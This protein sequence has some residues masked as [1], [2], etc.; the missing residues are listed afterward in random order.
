MHIN[1]RSG[2]LCGTLEQLAR[3]ARCKTA[4]FAHALADLQTTGTAA[5]TIRNGNVTVSNRR[6][7]REHKERQQ[8]KIRMQRFRGNGTVTPSVT[9][10]FALDVYT[11]TD[12]DTDLK[13][14]NDAKPPDT[15]TNGHLNRSSFN[16]SQEDEVMGRLRAFVGEDEMARAGGHWRQD[17]VRKHPGLVMRAIEDLESREKEGATYRNRGAALEDTIKRW[18]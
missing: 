5:V 17:H 10:K 15:P 1:G 14:L 13:R 9:Q 18:K 11:D 4:A 6:M 8:S 3:S 2:K 16:R 7:Q 12:T